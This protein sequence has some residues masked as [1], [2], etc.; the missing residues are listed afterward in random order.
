M[1][2][3]S[4]KRRLLVAGATLLFIG[5]GVTLISFEVF[6]RFTVEGTV[7]PELELRSID[8][9]AVRL[10]A[11][12][13]RRHLL[14]FF[15]VS[16]PHCQI[17]LEHLRRLRDV[18]RTCDL[19]A[20][21]LSNERET[22]SFAL[23]KEFP[24]SLWSMRAEDALVRLGVRRVPTMMFIDERDH[25]DR[26]RTGTRSF[27]EDSVL[28]VRYCRGSALGFSAV[29]SLG[30]DGSPMDLGFTSGSAAIQMD[31]PLLTT[32]MPR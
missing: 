8:G 5:G 15:L 6:N 30:E 23:E 27:A 31:S 25:V 32:V 3:V 11:P 7:R 17:E 12:Y 4:I 18:I 1:R 20:I 24:F 19:F 29:D 21:S 2:G 14:L 28:L 10:A 26:V 9:T 16:C 13:T 22:R